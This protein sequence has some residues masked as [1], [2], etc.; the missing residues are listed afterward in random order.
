MKNLVLFII[1]IISICCTQTIDAQHR[2][3][4]Q[5]SGEYQAASA[6]NPNALGGFATVG[7][8]NGQMQF[9]QHTL[10][11]GLVAPS[12]TYYHQ[13]QNFMEVVDIVYTKATCNLPE[14]YFITGNSRQ[15]GSATLNIFVARVRMNGFPVWYKE[16]PV[17]NSG[18]AKAIAIG[19]VPDATPSQPETNR[20]FVTGTTMNGISVAASLDHCGMP[21]WGPFTYNT[22]NVPTFPEDLAY[23]QC[24]NQ[25]ILTG[26]TNSATGLPNTWISSVD[27]STGA[28]NWCNNYPANNASGDYG[29]AV[30]V[31]GEEICV[32]GQANF[33]N[34]PNIYTMKLDCGGNPMWQ[35]IY[36]PTTS[37]SD[38][39]WGQDVIASSSA[40]GNFV[41]IGR[42]GGSGNTF[43]QELDAGGIPLPGS[44][45]IY[46][47]T[48]PSNLRD[49][50]TMNPS[51]P[52]GSYYISTNSSDNSGDYLGVWTPTPFQPLPCGPLDFPFDYIPQQGFVIGDCGIDLWEPWSDRVLDVV[53]IPLEQIDPCQ[54]HEPCEVY[55][56]FCFEVDLNTVTFSNLS[57]GNGSLSYSWDFGDGNTSTA[58]DPV[59][60]YAAPGT[61]YVC[62]TVINTLPDGTVCCY[63]C[64]KEITIFPPCYNNIP[65]P[66]FNY[67]YKNNGSI[68]F[69]N[70]SGVGG[71]FTKEWTIDGVYHSNLNQPPSITLTPGFHV[72]CLEVTKNSNPN[73]SEKFCR[74]I[75]VDEACTV[76]TTTKIV[77]ETCLN[78]TTVDFE[79]IAG[80]TNASTNYTWDYGDGNMGSGMNTTHTYGTYGTYM[81][82]VTIENTPNCIKT[83][84]AMINVSAPACSDTCGPFIRMATNSEDNVLDKWNDGK[85][86]Q[87]MP[88]PISNV[89]TAVFSE[90]QS[91]KATIII[92]DMSGKTVSQNSI[93]KGTRNYE[94]DMSD[95]PS[96]MYIMTLQHPDGKVTASKIIKE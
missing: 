47:L 5:S 57:S 10:A 85:E 51:D 13:D 69:N 56:D 87:I 34:T 58:M 73:C 1:L 35:N 43:I 18:G 94:F 45:F 14:G 8:S 88:N 95:L 82:C 83:M 65:G 41:V 4:P 15:P 67:L 63:T 84:C 46:P 23:L 39:T 27:A 76:P 40:F 66:T 54:D 19:Q 89:G 26:L 64:C 61:Y 20:V 11:A 37:T 29:T 32:T 90:I 2:V 48:V 96:G 86:L 75:W 81:V 28:P 24:E 21:V 80:A 77:Y 70:P 79:A 78:S 3:I 59:H 12:V 53:D 22:P 33:N 52:L 72:V 74:N 30:A 6:P 44:E 50:I 62:L 17:N 93:Q 55:T 60:T 71:A 7:N 68:K 36:L 25:V 49:Q 42:D 9:F 38:G 31:N 91:D 16:F 92:S